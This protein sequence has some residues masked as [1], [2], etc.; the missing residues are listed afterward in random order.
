MSSLVM[1]HTSA[2]TT[3]CQ[4]WLR[5]SGGRARSGLCECFG[6]ACVVVISMVCPRRRRKETAGDGVAG[7]GE[8]EELG[9]RALYLDPN[10]VTA[11]RQ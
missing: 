11:V 9:N 5:S 8:L 2:I 7:L 6:D 1:R 3:C 4:M 10:A